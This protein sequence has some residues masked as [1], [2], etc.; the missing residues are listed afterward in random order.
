MHF[1]T[2]LLR[3]KETFSILYKKNSYCPLII[4]SVLNVFKLN[5]KMVLYEVFSHS[6]K[7]RYL[8]SIFSRAS[9]VQFVCI[10]LSL[11]GPF[12]VA[13]Y[14]GGFWIKDKQFIEQARTNFQY[15]YICILEDDSNVYLS[16][17]YEN[18]NQIYI[19]DY[20]PSIRT[21]NILFK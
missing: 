18:V 20:K 9:I 8:T 21:V 11:L 16:S 6:V 15:R 3:E 2:I 5:R 17:S 14:T 13:Y 10:V 4:F 12:L 7:I 19:N 1:Y